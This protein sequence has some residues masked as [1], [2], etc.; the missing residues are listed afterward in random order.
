MITIQLRGLGEFCA[1][2][3]AQLKSI[4]NPASEDDKILRTVALTLQAKVHDRIHE[5]GT[6]SD[7][8]QIGTYSGGYMAVRTGQF[9]SNATFSKGKNKGQ[10]KPSGVFTK[11]ENKGKPRP[12]FNRGGDT[13]VVI[14][15][16]K[17]LELSYA[18]IPTEKGYGIGFIDASISIPN[19]EGNNVSS[20]DKVGYVENTYGKKIFNASEDERKLAPQIYRAEL[21]RRLNVQ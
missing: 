1:R 17:K 19:Y 12:K 3:I 2:R 14:S 10:T 20:M 4:V 15:L 21:K 7:G 9:K 13:K 18:V 6:A 16:T 11:G 5:S 8:S